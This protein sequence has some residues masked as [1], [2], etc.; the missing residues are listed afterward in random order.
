L[1]SRTPRLE[2]PAASV[3]IRLTCSPE[4]ASAA[5]GSVLTFV[6]PEAS[7]TIHMLYDRTRIDDEEAQA[8]AARIG[9]A[10]EA[11]AEDRSLKIAD[12]PLMTEAM[13]AE[14]LVTRNQTARDYDRAALAHQLIEA[15]VRKTLE[16]TALVCEGV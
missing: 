10:V 15:Q 7:G 14:L 9:I 11:Y 1:I 8:I 5:E 6:I 4:D 13:Q 2:M 16:A 3:A 12:L